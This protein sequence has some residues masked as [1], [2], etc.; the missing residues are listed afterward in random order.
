M[1][2]KENYKTQ[3]SGVKTQKELNQIVANEEAESSKNENTQKI[4][5]KNSIN[6]L[7]FLESDLMKD[8]ENEIDEGI[9]AEAINKVVEKAQQK[10]EEIKL[11]EKEST[12]K[13]IQKLEFLSELQQDYVKRLENVQTK[14]EFNQI[15][16]EAKAK[17][18]EIKSNKRETTK[19]EIQKLEFLGELQQD[20]VKRLECALTEQEFNQILEEAKAKNEEKKPNGND[21]KSNI[22]TTAVAV[23]VPVAVVVIAVGAVVIVLVIRRNKY[24]AIKD[25]SEKSSEI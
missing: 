21:S 1:Q 15:L 6:K 4:S 7:S 10:N 19:E 23:A 8:Y 2:N 12:K 16:E 13:E 24:S 9:D 22:D 25:S 5:A 14:H 18:E 3:I 11:N 17:N 20:Y